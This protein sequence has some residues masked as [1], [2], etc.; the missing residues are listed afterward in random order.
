MSKLLNSL[1]DTVSIAEIVGKSKP[2]KG[3]PAAQGTPR[4]ARAEPPRP[5]PTHS[6]TPRSERPRGRPGGLFRRARLLAVAALLGG[7]AWWVL[8]QAAGGASAPRFEW[9]EVKRGDMAL[10]VATSGTL[11]PLVS[12]KV[13]SPV[14]G[15]V[16]QVLVDFGAKVQA[17]QVLAKLDDASLVADL[18][19]ARLGVEKARAAL[20]L[21][22]RNTKYAVAS[23]E[24]GLISAADYDKVIGAEKQVHG[25]LKVAEAASR[26]VAMAAEQGTIRSPID[27]VVLARNVEVGQS[28]SPDSGPTAIPLF[29]IAE[30]PN[31]MQIEASV[32]EADIGQV[33]VGQKVTFSVD[34][35]PGK[36]FKGEVAQVRGAPTTDQNVVT[37]PV[38]VRIKN[39]GDLRPGMTANLSILVVNREDVLRIP[40]A[41]LK[42]KPP[43]DLNEPKPGLF[44]SLFA[45]ETAP[46]GAQPPDA[47]KPHSKKS[48]SGKH[49]KKSKAAKAEDQADGAAPAPPE[50]KP[51]D[52][53]PADAAAPA[54]EAAASPDSE[55]LQSPKPDAENVDPGAD[56]N[57]DQDT[58]KKKDGKKRK[59]DGP[60]VYRLA[61][62]SGSGGSLE[63]ISV[64]T[65]LSDG[66]YTEILDGLQEGDR[67]V[68]SVDVPKESGLL[69]GIPSLLTGGGKKKKDR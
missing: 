19:V 53:A 6:T 5:E 40:N 62:A 25:D 15:T 45:A 54:P 55:T 66:R 59:G 4:W 46:D 32:V 24:A 31:L 56:Q 16:S 63:K 28:V 7:A 2:P 34:A 17:G 36:E 18:Q 35:F 3:K 65:G 37:Y 33:S 29:D 67:V 41:A 9:E 10:A 69:S 11:T 44:G 27:G 38:I 23:K 39:A 30:D 68:V 22:R 43:K 60:T 12:A 13:M 64:T 50:A 20:D 1:R 47:D 58:D 8:S 57:A 42:F 48:H 49:S 21:A 52:P 51:A 14:S 26:K 61:G